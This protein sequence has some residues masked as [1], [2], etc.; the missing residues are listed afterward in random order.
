MVHY[1]SDGIF[2][3]SLEKLWKYLSSEEHTHSA[4]K[5]YRVASESGNEVTIDAELF[6]PDGKTTSKATFTH[7]MNPPTSWE[8]TVKGGAMDGAVF[9]HTYTPMGDKT[10]VELKGDYKAI[11]GMSESAQL[12]ML[13]DFYTT[14]FKED[15]ANLQK[16][17]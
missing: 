2:D 16:M 17:Q 13:D 8:T 6:N 7:R 3:A 10:K 12:K 9:K 5:S 4:F 11:P 1:E 14:G 15:N